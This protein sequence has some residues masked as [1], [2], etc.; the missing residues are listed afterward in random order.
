MNYNIFNG[1]LD[2]NT[3]IKCKLL[4]I[5]STVKQFQFKAT[6]ESQERS[7]NSILRALLCV[8]NPERSSLIEEIDT[9]LL[10]EVSNAPQEITDTE[11]IKSFLYK[12]IRIVAAKDKKFKQ[13][14]LDTGNL[15]IDTSHTIVCKFVTISLYAELLTTLRSELLSEEHHDES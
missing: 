14:L 2:I 13:E 11:I 5:Q 4:R 1:I 6:D 12:I 9:H 15:K 10:I 3:S 7:Y 8:I